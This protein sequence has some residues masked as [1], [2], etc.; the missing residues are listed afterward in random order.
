MLV[1]NLL[2]ESLFWLSLVALLTMCVSLDW[3]ENSFKILR[4]G[5]LK[6]IEEEQ[7][8]IFDVQADQRSGSMPGILVVDDIMYLRSMRREVYVIARDHSVPFISVWV[9]ASLETALA[10]NMLRMGKEYIDEITIWKIHAELEPPNPVMIF[11][12]HSIT[13]DGEDNERYLLCTIAQ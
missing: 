1:E 3:D 9:K 12:R 11:D 2:G 13:I 7:A 8:R 6:R 10:R 4:N 5:N